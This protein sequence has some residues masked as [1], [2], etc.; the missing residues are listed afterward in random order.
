M[1]SSST[2]GS[3]SKSLIPLLVGL[4]AG[5]ALGYLTAWYLK[6][7]V[8]PSTVKHVFLGKFK[9]GTTEEEVQKLIEG[10]S[11]LPKSIKSM[12]AFE[13]YVTSQPGTP[14]REYS[15]VQWC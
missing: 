13:W 6:P 12:K 10:Y 9:D 14:N 2:S 8:T 3:G 5:S 1:S 15:T 11:A 4:A 7:R